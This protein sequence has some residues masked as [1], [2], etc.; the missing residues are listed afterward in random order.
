GF[1]HLHT[2][3]DPRRVPPLFQEIQPDLVLLDLRMPHLDGLSLF[4]Q[5]RNQI[6]ADTYLPFL[7]LTAD[8]SDRAR[9]EALSLGAK[10]FVTKP[11]D[12]MEVVLRSYN[13]LETRFLHL[14]LQRHNRTLEARVQERTRELKETQVEILRRLALAAEFRDDDTGQHTQRVGRLA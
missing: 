7:I 11:F 1:Q 4:K 14:E 10:D 8:S 3:S 6:P 13:L 5:L 2:F 12:Q 9:K